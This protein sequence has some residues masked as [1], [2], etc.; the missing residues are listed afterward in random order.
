M[1]TGSMDNTA[2]LW[3]IETN[4]QLMK[5]DVSVLKFISRPTL[6]RLLTLV[7]TPMETKF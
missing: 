1:A 3:N 5:I 6:E 7:L 2:L 4:Q